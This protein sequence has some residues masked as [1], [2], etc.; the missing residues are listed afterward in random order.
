M[1][2][3]RPDRLER[4]LNSCHYCSCCEWHQPDPWVPEPDDDAG[5][6]TVAIYHRQNCAWVHSRGK[7]TNERND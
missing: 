4:H 1:S 6:A 2:D 3:K 7:L 5:W